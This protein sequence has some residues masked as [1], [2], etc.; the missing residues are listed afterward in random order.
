[1]SRDEA[2][3]RALLA[4]FARA[5]HEKD[6][7][8][9]V[10]HYAREAVVFDLATP[11]RSQIGTDPRAFQAWLDTWEGPIELDWRDLQVAVDGDLAFCHGFLC[12]AGTSR[13]EGRAIRLWV[14]ATYGLRRDG[15][16]WRV[17]HEH[18]SVPFYMDGSFRAA[19]DLEP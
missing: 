12:L 5:H 11:L 8:A 1:M 2:D 7:H 16:R 4:A 13:A 15:G 19:V 18:T 10:A 9:A 3:I 6:G 14:R 17:A